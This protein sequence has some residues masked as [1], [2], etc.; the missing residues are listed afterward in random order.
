MTS[1]PAILEREAARA[2]QG[3]PE[4]IA[5]AARTAASVTTG[6][7]ARQRPGRSDTFWQFRDYAPGDPAS[8][9][10]WRQSA[11]LERRLLVRQTEWEQPQTYL[12]WCD[13]DED[14][15][16]AGDARPSKR[17]RGQTIAL[18]LAMVL[19]RSGERVGLWG[20]GE[21]PVCGAQSIPS[22]AHQLLAP[23]ADLSGIVPLEGACTVLLSDFHR[24]PA[25]LHAA[26]ARVRQVHGQAIA[27]IVEDPLE[28]A[29]PYQGATKFEGPAGTRRK[30][31]GDAGSISEAYHAARQDHLM[32]LKDAARLPH[33]TVFFHTTDQSPNPLVL[34]LLQHIRGEV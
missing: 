16:F 15:D 31:F 14:F 6:R 18:A 29:F 1:Q 10:D 5:A 28:K 11:R 30:R 13:G 7:H 26:F 20:G 8:S 9:I 32:A 21:S 23:Q 34:K 33:E 19:L 3:L 25:D 22:V 17:F 24:P 2:A 12:L 27:V 4:L